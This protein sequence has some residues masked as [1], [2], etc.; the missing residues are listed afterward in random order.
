MQIHRFTSVVQ[1]QVLRTSHMINQNNEM[2][3]GMNKSKVVL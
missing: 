3:A 1:E 2:H